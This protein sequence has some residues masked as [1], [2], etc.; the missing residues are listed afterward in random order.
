MPVFYKSETTNWT[1]KP[2]QGKPHGSRNIVEI[3][4]GKGIK[5]K[6]VLTETGNV[7]HHHK[8][9]LKNKEIKHIL[10]GKFLPGLWSDV[11]IPVCLPIQNSK[12][13][14]KSNSS[15]TRK[16]KHKKHA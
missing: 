6:E 4:N 1:S 10:K 13:S 2:G 16:S 8:H 7:K 9:T 5:I 12:N 11:I 3:K 15:K 14:K